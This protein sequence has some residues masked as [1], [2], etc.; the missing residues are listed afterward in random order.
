MTTQEIAGQGEA[1]NPKQEVLIQ[2]NHL[3]LIARDILVKRYFVPEKNIVKI[4][5]LKSKDKKKKK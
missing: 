3:D 5:D 4:D 1:R 2:G